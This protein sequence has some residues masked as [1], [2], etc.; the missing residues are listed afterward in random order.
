MY[1]YI[2]LVVSHTYMYISV[3][4]LQW[5]FYFVKWFMLHTF[6]LPTAW[7]RRPDILSEQFS[8]NCGLHWTCAIM[9]LSPSYSKSFPFIT[10]HT[11]LCT[12]YYHNVHCVIKL[13]MSCGSSMYNFSYV[14]EILCLLSKTHEH[15]CVLFL[16]LTLYCLLCTLLLCLSPPSTSLSSPLALSRTMSTLYPV[17]SIECALVGSW[18]L[19]S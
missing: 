10:S 19:P 6:S 16:L 2:L 7:D 11:R 12:P 14:V 13:L 15:S 9:I 17:L 18:A 8:R 1:L 4:T 5:E 3:L